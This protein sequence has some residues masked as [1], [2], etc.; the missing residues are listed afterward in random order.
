MVFVLRICNK[1]IT[2]HQNN[3]TSRTPGLHCCG[4]WL[5]WGR[6]S[7]GRIKETP[8][9]IS[10]RKNDESMT[11]SA[12]RRIYLLAFA[13]RTQNRGLDVDSSV[14]VRRLD[15]H[16]PLLVTLGN[17]THG[18]LVDH[19]LRLETHLELALEKRARHFRACVRTQS[20]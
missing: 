18:L 8:G 11:F 9:L 13:G 15:P 2:S 19:P 1:S 20:I 14:E 16:C 10:F 17:L 4:I 3:D 5:L 7:V 6:E 12:N